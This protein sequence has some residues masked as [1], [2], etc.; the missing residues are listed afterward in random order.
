MAEKE[1]RVYR[2]K[3]AEQAERYE[4][5]VCVLFCEL[6]VFAELQ[7][8]FSMEFC[9]MLVIT[10]CCSCQF[11]CRYFSFLN[12]GYVGKVTPCAMNIASDFKSKCDSTS[13]STKNSYFCL[14][15]LWLHT[16]FLLCLTDI[17]GLFCRLLQKW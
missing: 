9:F 1:K 8:G 13:I 4:G 5:T 14:P 11:I 17:Q 16:R 2:A 10:I 12:K 15:L 3:L 6:R 7:C